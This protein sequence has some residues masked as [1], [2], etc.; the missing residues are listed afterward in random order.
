VTHVV[1]THEHGDHTAGNCGVVAATGA[2]VLTHAN[3]VA[4][5]GQVD[6][7]LRDGDSIA[8]G[9]SVRLRAL[10]TPGHTMA[11]VCLLAGEDLF[12]GDTLFNAGVGRCRG[13]GD[14]AVLFDTFATVFASLPDAVRVHP[15]HEYLRRNLGFSVDREPGNAR[16][17]RLL[18]RIENIEGAAVPTLTLGD[19][20]EINAFLRL[21]APEVAARAVPGRG[22][23]RA[24]DK[25][26]FLALR[27]LNDRW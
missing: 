2:R 5:V 19:E 26:V 25:E 15:G 6:Q 4:R 18:E 8:V 24:S 20:R 12:T 9:S 17:R 13:G 3:A 7:A 11:H 14:P 1:N 10:E 21:D 16:A 27:A 22:S 23:G